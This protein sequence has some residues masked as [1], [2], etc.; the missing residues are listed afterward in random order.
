MRSGLAE[1][2]KHMLI[3]LDPH[4]VLQRIERLPKGTAL[5]GDAFSDLI[6]ESVAIKRDIVVQD[7]T[8][9]TGTRKT[10][11][12]SAIP[13][14]TPSNRGPCRKATTCS[15]E[16]PWRGL[17]VELAVSAGRSGL[18]SEPGR[19]LMTLAEAI[20]RAMPARPSRPPQ[21]CCGHGPWMDKKNEGDRVQMVLLSGDGSPEVDQSVSFDEFDAACRAVSPTGTAPA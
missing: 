9:S 3:A 6:L 11:S 18:E 15:T 17:G 19:L 1:H 12:T 16:K 5:D 7:P 21:M 8:E 13:R 4:S 20:Q 2:V 10:T 14:D